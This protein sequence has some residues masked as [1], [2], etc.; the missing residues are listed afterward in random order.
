MP[1]TPRDSSGH[2]A[3]TAFT[4]LV[5]G[6]RNWDNIARIR[7][8][9]VRV[10]DLADSLDVAPSQITLVHG[11]AQGADRTA[12]TFATMLGFNVVSVP[13]Q[14]NK[15]HFVDGEQACRCDIPNVKFCKMAGIHRN[16]EMLNT[17][18]PDMVVAFNRDNSAGTMHTISES[19]RR[20]LITNVVR[21]EDTDKADA[22]TS[23]TVS[24][25]SSHNSVTAA[26][27]AQ[28]TDDPFVQYQ[29]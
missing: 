23:D 21:Y 28:V 27:N 10:K 18:K 16:L 13:A 7:D 15:H 2:F 26:P 8:E 14:W 1:T 6:S 17:Y 20:G 12:G 19:R 9:L 5:T 4:V 3:K 24:D 29:V 25:G 11:N 22:V